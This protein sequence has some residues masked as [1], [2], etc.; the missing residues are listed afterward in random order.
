[1]KKESNEER[2]DK[3]KGRQKGVRDED[4]KQI[5]PVECEQAFANR[6]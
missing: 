3:I 1:L 5:F 4:T 6:K 2:S